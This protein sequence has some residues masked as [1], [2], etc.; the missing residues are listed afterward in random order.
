[1]M[2]RHVS[3]C[4]PPY[5]PSRRRRNPDTLYR[6]VLLQT[7]VSGAR[8]YWIVCEA[9]T[10]NPLRRFSRSSYLE[11]IHERERAHVATSERAALQETGSKELELTSLWMDRTKWPEVYDGARRELLVR[12]SQVGKKKWSRNGDFV[13]GEHQGVCLVSCAADE[14][15]IRRLMAAL[16]RALDR[17]EETMRRTGHPILCWLNSGSHNRFDQRPF[18]FL[19]KAA[20]R[21]RYRRLFARF[22][23]FFFRAYNI[24]LAV[25]VSVLGIRFTKKE[26]TELKKVW[27]DEAW[28]EEENDPDDREEKR[29][30]CYDNDF[31][32]ESGC[33]DDKDDDEHEDDKEDNKDDEDEEEEEEDG[34]REGSEGD[35]TE[36]DREGSHKDDL[37]SQTDESEDRSSQ[38]SDE[39]HAPEVDKLAEIVFCLSVFFI[40]EEFTDG[41]PSSNPLVY[42]SGVLGFSDDGST[43]RRAKDYTPQLS[44]LIYI[45]RLL[46][47]EFAL[48]SRAYT[49]V[50][51][52]QRPPQG[53]LEILNNVRLKCMVLGCLTPLGEFI[54]LRARGRKLARAD[55]PSFLARWSDDGNILSYGDTSISIENFRRFGHALVQQ[56]EVL[57]DSL[58]FNWLPQVDLNHVKDDMSNTTRGYSFL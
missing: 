42:Y 15:K 13:I 18:A 50:C 39:T 16:D 57:C 2:T 44:A 41:Q 32:W 36:H 58:M 30:L 9:S 14:L 20:T 56:A 52:P 6:D 23:P 4:C 45:Q 43:F 31:E 48:P 17:C 37:V 51:L 35:E 1:M 21:Q 55:P 19:G 22:L 12:I 53:H 7:W 11:A 25:R 33:E 38:N 49:Y 28:E 29:W 10:P 40:T 3:S 47:L 54:S 34:E 27:D 8:K 24:P 26:L 5:P 46:L